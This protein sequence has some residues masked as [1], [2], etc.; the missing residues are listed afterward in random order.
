M[1][2][3]ICWGESEANTTKESSSRCAETRPTLRYEVV[4]PIC[5]IFYPI[6]QPSWR[7]ALRRRRLVTKLLRN[8]PAWQ[9]IKISVQVAR[10]ARTADDHDRGALPRACCRNRASHAGSSARHK[11]DPACHGSSHGA[12]TS[13]PP[14]GE[15][16]RTLR[17]ELRRSNCAGRG[18]NCAA[19]GATASPTGADT[20]GRSPPFQRFVAQFLS[21][22][23][24][25]PREAVRQ[26][27][28]GCS[29][30]CLRGDT[31]QSSSTPLG[32]TKPMVRVEIQRSRDPAREESKI[33]VFASKE[34][35]H[36]AE[37]A[38]L[39]LSAST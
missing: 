18:R 37:E 25:P 17:M 33:M 23:K 32:A 5:Y 22:L 13:S 1:R 9:G 29:A 16:G 31:N 28:L 14:A 20:T 38:P 3:F 21:N 8:Y 7:P 39:T 36:V 24:T 10:R 15:M 34:R 6:R 12:S 27:L 2:R 35:K 19:L 30:A 26:V 4:L 11:T